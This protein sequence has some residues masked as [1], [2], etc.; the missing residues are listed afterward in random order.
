[1]NCAPFELIC[2]R[3]KLICL[4]QK[5]RIYLLLTSFRE[6]ELECFDIVFGVVVTILADRSED[7]IIVSG[8]H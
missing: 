5:L 6:C 1:M 4:R 3:Q 7:A 8:Q 2:L